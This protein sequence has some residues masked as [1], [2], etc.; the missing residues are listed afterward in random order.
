MAIFSKGMKKPGTGWRGKDQYFA[1]KTKTDD[2]TGVLMQCIFANTPVVSPKKTPRVRGLHVN[3]IVA[4][5]RCHRGAALP[6]MKQLSIFL[7]RYQLQYKNRA[8][9]VNVDYKSLN[10]QPLT[11]D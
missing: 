6:S 9:I 3:Y 5:R 11:D 4:Y 10:T 8:L 2:T 7:A 1:E